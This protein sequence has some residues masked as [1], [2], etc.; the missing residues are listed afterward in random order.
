VGFLFFTKEKQK[1]SGL[2]SLSCNKM[3]WRGNREPRSGGIAGD[4]KKV[5]RKLFKHDL[6]MEYSDTIKKGLMAG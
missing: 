3:Q 6:N 5:R 4:L 2:G 1:L